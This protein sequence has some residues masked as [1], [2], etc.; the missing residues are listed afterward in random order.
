MVSTLLSIFRF[1]TRWFSDGVSVVNEY[2]L[3]NNVIN[4]ETYTAVNAG[5]KIDTNTTGNGTTDGT[6]EDEDSAR[7]MKLSLIIGGSVLLIL[8]IIIL[9][10]YYC[11]C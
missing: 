1:E 8:L 9:I 6:A 2:L 5:S 10:A 7:I 11:F 3:K 4:T